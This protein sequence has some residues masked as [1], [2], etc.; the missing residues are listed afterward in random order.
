MCLIVL[1]WQA[2][3]DYPLVVAANRDE[4]FSRPAA[5]ATFWPEA[6]QVLAGRDLEAGGTWLGVSR[7]QR[8]AALTNYRDGSKQLVDA[9]SRG[10]LVADFLTGNTRSDAYLAQVAAASAAY[11]G[12]N[13][14]VGDGESL[15]YYSNRG[16][17]PP[18]RL[19][20]GVYGLSNHL[21]D[22]QWPKL[23][24]AK[25]AFAEAL[26]TLPA[27]APFFELLADQEIVPDSHLPET[28]VPLEWERILSAVFVRS[29]NYGT[30][31]AT[32]LTRHRNGQTCLVERSFDEAAVVVGEVCEAF[33][34]SLISTC[35]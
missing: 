16:D 22:T 18:R 32:L 6:P 30:R 17:D 23:A 5:P 2:H 14:F 3:P 4:F 29:E 11:N 35:V 9:R 31:A 20:P 1:A 19:M 27:Q 12:F 25:A 34:S 13:L 7:G 8:F 21:L 33:Q 15:A 26:T 10:A 24:S 28:G